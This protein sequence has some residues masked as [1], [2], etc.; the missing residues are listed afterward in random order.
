MPKMPLLQG[1]G[2]TETMGTRLIHLLIHWGIQSL[3]RGGVG[4][5]THLVL[6]IRGGDGGGK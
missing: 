4:W 6:V 2:K 3:R 1:T 5:D